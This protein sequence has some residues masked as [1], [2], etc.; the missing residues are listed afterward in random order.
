MARRHLLNFTTYTFPG[1]M[2]NWHHRVMCEY[3][4]RWVAGDITRLMI[5]MPPRSG[6]LCKDSTPVLTTKGWK[7]HGDLEIGDE[8]FGENGKP[9]PV[10]NVFNVGMIADH[11]VT[12][13]DGSKIQ[14]HGDHEWVVRDRGSGKWKVME[15][16]DLAKKG[17]RYLESP[18]TGKVRRRYSVPNVSALEFEEKVLPVHPYFLGAWLGDGKSDGPT[19]CYAE[20]NSG[21]IERCIGVCNS[22]LGSHHVHP[23]TG[24][25]YQY[26]KGVTGLLRDLGLMGSSKEVREQREAVSPSK[27]IP[28][29]YKYSSIEQRLEL[30][31]GLIDTDGC[32]EEK[33]GRVMFSNC[34]KRLIDD[35]MEVAT[36]LGFRPYV[37][38]END[39]KMSTSGINGRQVVYVVGFNPTMQIPTVLPQKKITRLIKQRM[40]FVD[41]IEGCEPEPGKCIQVGSDDGIYLVGRNLVP[42]H[43]S[44][45]VSRRLP[46]WIFGRDPDASIITASYNMDLAR[47]MN[48]DVQRI[49]DDPKYREVFPEVSLNSKNVATDRRGSYLRNADIFEIV[50]RHG[51][52]KTA[53]IGT[54]ITGMGGD[55]LIIDDPVKDRETA[56]SKAF[57]EKTW[58][59]YTSTFYTR[60]MTDESRIL[61]TLTRWTSKDLAG[62]LLSLGEG[63][64]D[65]DKWV[66]VSFPM[67]ATERL[68]PEDPR[69][70]GDPLWPDR[71]SMASL[72]ATRATMGSYDWA[73]LM[74]Q[75]PIASAGT[76]FER[77]W[78]Q[79]YDEDPHT[80]IKEMEEVIMV[81][82]LAVKEKRD[83]NV[84]QVWGRKGIDKYLL[85]QYRS[86]GDFTETL[87]A[88]KE[89]CGAWPEARKKLVEDKANGPAI[90]SA[91][92]N[93]ISG[94]LPV[95]DGGKSKE[96]RAMAASPDV[97]SKHVFVPN[98]G[99]R[100][101][102]WVDEWLQE[103]CDFPNGDYDDQ[104]DPFVYAVNYFVK[105]RTIIPPRMTAIKPV[106]LQSPDLVRVVAGRGERVR[107]SN[108]RTGRSLSVKPPW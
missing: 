83:Y 75:D 70:P 66:V 105:P 2:V 11:V 59:W 78:F 4:E 86:Q 49:I 104:V 84:G 48:R 8:V 69:K 79:F 26:F 46:P 28:D 85:G 33:T 36:S 68:S 87:Y 58:D 90:M 72:I 22:E 20:R 71:F 63:N 93:E 29:L 9:I 53:G 100:R 17:L 3:L 94:I 61:I 60:R 77:G 107:R 38:S 43:N 19:I 15:T 40:V 80:L 65:A 108:G 10:V 67:I 42:T 62:K 7:R 95:P 21:V 44:E 1:Y 35:V 25:H 64:E 73:A 89:F 30:L 45:L 88:F 34:N 76:T 13:S 23:T 55:Y 24:V 74:Q 96:I 50:G 16:R 92:R 98:P 91:L 52:Y 39:P 54:G 82:D 103:V 41:S 99:P 101:N 31:A 5:F 106:V 37:A 97:E 32:V 47:R 12:F 56:E 102:H 81:W 51:V 57:Q 27:C 18:K 6:K 14:V